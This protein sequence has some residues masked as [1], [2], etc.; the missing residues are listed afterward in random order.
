MKEFFLTSLVSVAVSVMIFSISAPMLPSACY[1]NDN[2]SMNQDSLCS[3]M[4]KIDTLS[5]SSKGRSFVLACKYRMFEELFLAEAGKTAK[6]LILTLPQDVVAKAFTWSPEGKYVAFVTYNISGHSPVT[7]THTWIMD[8]L[9]GKAGKIVL[10]NPYSRFSTFSPRW[11]GDD[12]LFVK[13]LVLSNQ[14]DAIERE[15]VYIGN[16]KSVGIYPYYERK[17]R[18]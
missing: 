18:K 9:R 16:A 17:K 11:G 8:A 3:T 7:T 1:N 14:G 6:K 10:P 13:A 12:S 4:Y 5:V 15:Y 2:T